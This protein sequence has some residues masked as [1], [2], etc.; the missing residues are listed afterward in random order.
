MVMVEMVFS[1]TG[2]L[3]QLVHQTALAVEDTLYRHALKWSPDYPVTMREAL[4]LGLQQQI[5]GGYACQC[6][7]ATA[8]EVKAYRV[9]LALPDGGLRAWTNQLVGRILAGCKEEDSPEGSKLRKEL[10]RTLVAQLGPFLER[11]ELPP[12]LAGTPF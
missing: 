2:G 12:M 3:D 7:S 10:Q 1:G 6:V 5:V 8:D 4:R 9:W 11:S